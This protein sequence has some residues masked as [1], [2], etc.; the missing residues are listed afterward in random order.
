MADSETLPEFVRDSKLNTIFLNDRN[1]QFITSHIKLWRHIRE[2]WIQRGDIGAGS[3][4]IV[5]LEARLGGGNSDSRTL[6]A[7]K[8]IRKHRSSSGTVRYVRE[9]EA[10]A[11]F[12]QDKVNGTLAINTMSDE[13]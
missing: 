5:R 8:E 4:G 6:R 10:L 9:L 13:T 12:S 7:V 3:Y 1:G 2:D 11:K